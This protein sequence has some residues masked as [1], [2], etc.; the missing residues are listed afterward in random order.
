VSVGGARTRTG[1][2]P[3]G[4]ILGARQA[5]GR[6]DVAGEQSGP[7]IA[8]AVFVVIACV[9]PGLLVGGL[10]GEIRADLG[11][12]GFSIGLA[13]AIFWLTAAVASSPGGRLVDRLGP[14]TGIRLGGALA[15]AG[16]F[17]AAAASSPAVLTASLAVGGSANAFATPGVS[18]LASSAVPRERQGFAFGVQLGGP[19]IAALLAGLA[20]PLIAGPTGW[21]TSFIVAA[22][23]ALAAATI[24]PQASATALSAVSGSASHRLRPLML[25][26][27]GAAAAN[28][29]AGAVLTFLVIYC[30]E[31]G[32]SPASAGALLVAA[33]GGAVA[34]RLGLGALADRHPDA[35]LGW[36]VWL[37]ALGAAGYSLLTSAEPTLVAL[38]AVVAIGLGWGWPGVLLFAV[39]NRHRAD[40][41]A[42][43]GVVITGFFAGAVIGPL[44]AG[45]LV[46]DG[47]YELIWWLCG[48]LAVLAAASIDAGRRALDADPSPA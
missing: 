5:S 20:L 32:L 37:L 42:A 8:R 33:S 9:Y 24:A 3:R 29:A 6:C 12:S 47:S 13:A 40:P 43:V 2:T 25:L 14:T 41:G 10:A 30:L 36:L 34:V 38:G 11:L 48:G 23:L 44:A 15:A 17:G 39:V 16:A 27:A 19:A 4:R 22:G 31:I 21:R 7:I 45:P 1:R 26:A 35:A 46:G 18:A 28:A